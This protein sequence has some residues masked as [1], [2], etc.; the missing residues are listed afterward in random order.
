MKTK[1]LIELITLSSSIYH[2]AKNTHLLEKIGELSDK[3]K[4]SLNKIASESVLD[5]EGNEMELIDKLVRK[6]SQAKE[7]LEQRIEELVAQFYKKINI[8]HADEI[9][10]LDSRLEKADMKIAL[11]EA[12]LNRLEGK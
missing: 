8:A 4:E 7:E 9:K 11:L 6:T 2:L 1:T 5:D 3:G 10:G 12:R